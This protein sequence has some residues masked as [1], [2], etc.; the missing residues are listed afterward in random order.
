MRNMFSF[1][2]IASV[3]YFVQQFGHIDDIIKHL[4][5]LKHNKQEGSTGGIKNNS[6]IVS[7]CRDCATVYVSFLANL[8]QMRQGKG[9]KLWNRYGM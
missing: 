2:N 7:Y 5:I 4:E 6:N 8:L 3:T 9:T 1:A